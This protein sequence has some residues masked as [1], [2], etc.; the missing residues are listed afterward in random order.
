MSEAV[1]LSDGNHCPTRL[2]CADQFFGRAGGAV[3][4]P[5]TTSV[6]FGRSPAKHSEH[7]LGGT[8]L[9]CAVRNGMASA[10]T[11]NTAPRAR[12]MESHLRWVGKY[13]PAA[14]NAMAPTT[15]QL[16]GRHA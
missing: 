11:N 7:A 4:T 8:S 5:T 10:P 1:A 16:E 12:K 3:R 14:T 13:A 2:E 9:P 6:S 15:H